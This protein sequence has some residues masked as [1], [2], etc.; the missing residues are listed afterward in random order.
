MCRSDWC[1]PPG[2]FEELQVVDAASAFEIDEGAER[3]FARPGLNGQC[4]QVLDVIALDAP[5]CPRAAAPGTIEERLSSSRQAGSTSLLVLPAGSSSGAYHSAVVSARRR[6]F[7][8][9][10]DAKRMRRPRPATPALP[11]RSADASARRNR[12]RRRRS[13]SLC[14]RRSRSAAAAAT[15]APGARPRRSSA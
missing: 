3:A 11:R 2:D 8:A 13:G 9:R 14:R 7:S 1:L 6:A 15:R 12:S 4:G 10:A 5:G